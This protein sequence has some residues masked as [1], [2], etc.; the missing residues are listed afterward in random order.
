MLTTE[1][2]AKQIRE[3]KIGELHEL[4]L[5]KKM[6]IEKNWRY[7]NLQIETIDEESLNR[8]TH[9]SKEYLRLMRKYLRLTGIIKS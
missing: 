9:L 4:L 2:Y 6:E 1:E 3:Q 5:Q 7:H 8:D